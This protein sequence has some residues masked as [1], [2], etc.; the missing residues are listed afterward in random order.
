VPWISRVTA[1]PTASTD[2]YLEVGDKRVF[3]CAYD[4]PGWC[5]SG[6]N[7]DAALEALGAYRD[8]YVVVTRYAGIRAPSPELA[9][10]DRVP[11][12]V[13]TSFGVPGAIAPRDADALTAP[14]R[15]R[16]IALLG[17]AWTVFDEVVA[18]APAILRKG[19]RGGGRDRDKIVDHVFGAEVVYLNAQRVKLRQP[20]GSDAEAIAA[21]RS[22]VVEA[23]NEPAPDA[24]WPV[25]YAVRRFAWHALDHAWEIEDRSEPPI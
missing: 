5:R 22:A 6:R 2:V 21:F 13:S 20:E 24:R 11:G 9:V 10:V 1:T 23:L 12:S 14:Q 25:R 17:A 7:E 4:W 18:G 19:P 16:L 15:R 8:R 3:A